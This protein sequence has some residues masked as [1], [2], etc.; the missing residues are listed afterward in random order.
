MSR[1]FALL[2]SVLLLTFSMPTAPTA[3]SLDAEQSS[4]VDFAQRQFSAA[5]IDL[6]NVEIDFPDDPA[7]CFGYGGIYT[8]SKRLIRICRPSKST[9]IHEFAHAWIETSFS[10]ADKEAFL[11]HRGLD[12]WV[13]GSEWNL[14]G[15]EQAAEIIT[16]A[17]MDEDITHRWIE[18]DYGSMSET[19]R[20][21]KVPNSDL[22]QLVSAY[23][24]LTGSTPNNRA[25][26][27]R[28]TTEP[29]QEIT[30]P[31]ADRR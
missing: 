14:R 25:D 3:P 15:A 11:E 10:E 7:S 26:D 29:V 19:R 20:L 6:P 31:E 12:S 5:G 28:R 21:L 1:I 30:S 24:Q 2:T 13:G 4:L 22:E 23:T 18:T 8:P 9:M 17:L 16:W 27:L